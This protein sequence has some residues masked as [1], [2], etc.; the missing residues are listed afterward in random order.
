MSD[1][2]K[3][4]LKLGQEDTNEEVSFQVMKSV[5]ETLDEYQKERF[6]KNIIER[7]E[8]SVEDLQPLL[9]ELSD[10]SKDNPNLPGVLSELRSHIV[11]PRLNIFRKI[12]RLPGGLKFLLD[13][14]GDLLSIQRFSQSNLKPLESDLTLL[15][16][17]WFQEG[18][19]YLEEITLDSSY[20]QIELIKKSDLV[21]PM[22]SIEEM[23]QRLGRD[24]RCFALYHRLIPYEPIIFI[25]VALSKGILRNIA[26]IINRDKN[27]TEEKDADTAIFYSINN[28]Q[29]GLTGL[30]MGK[31]L[32]GQVVDYL[33]EDNEKI[34]KFA[35][36]SPLP[37]FWKR[38]FKPILEGKDEPFI[39]KH[40]DVV[41]YFFKKQQEKIMAYAGLQE[42][43]TEQLNASLLSIL[44]DESW[45]ENK[46]LRESLHDPLVKVAYTYIS[47]EKNLKNKPL[48]PVAN[49]HLGNEATVSLKN[50]N[51]LGNPTS[52]GLDESCGI[53]VNYIYTSGWLARIQ[54]SLKRFGK[55][56]VT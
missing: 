41:S 46:E 54:R 11:S 23:G 13:F 35:T 15:F 28:T 26:D 20:R 29:N 8:I 10:C 9:D 45:S 16:E 43:N 37:G 3:I 5:Y 42:F 18:F 38:Y 53:M 49:F 22:N 34:K 32:I 50:V 44:S 52:K 24:R 19:V 6:F 14:R 31:M 51:F 12:S 27:R 30:G 40:M 7:I 55:M 33:K 47:K 48:N 2:L 25:E 21:H 39:L 4:F 36:L 17:L 56:E 1:I